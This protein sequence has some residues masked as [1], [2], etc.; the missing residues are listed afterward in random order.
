M[1]SNVL[2]EKWGSE[3]QI[4]DRHNS[5]PHKHEL[6]EDITTVE[7]RAKAPTSFAVKPALPEYVVVALVAGAFKRLKVPIASNRDLGIIREAVARYI[8]AIQASLR[9]VSKTQLTQKGY[10]AEEIDVIEL[11]ALEA[12]DSAG[13]ITPSPWLHVIVCSF[14]PKTR[15][16]CKG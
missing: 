4:F 5:S 7:K 6:K 14:K 13:C 12:T 1:I 8:P 11:A 10:F 16:K 15:F 9:T 2:P 3:D